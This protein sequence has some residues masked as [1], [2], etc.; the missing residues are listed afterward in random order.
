[1]PEGPPARDRR[2]MRTRTTD[3]ALLASLATG[4]VAAAAAASV[5]LYMIGD[6]ASQSGEFLD[7]VGLV[8]GGGLLVLVGVPA[9]LAARAGQLVLARRPR[10]T[11]FALAAGLT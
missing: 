10:A 6:D 8:I 9:G 2:P 4:L 11:A 3:I 1:M 7:G 5:A